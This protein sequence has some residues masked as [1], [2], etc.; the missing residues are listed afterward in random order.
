MLD[1]ERDVALG[2]SFFSEKYCTKPKEAYFSKAIPH[3]SPKNGVEEEKE[4]KTTKEIPKQ[5]VQNTA[6][7]VKVK[8]RKELEKEVRTKEVEKNICYVQSLRKEEKR[9]TSRLR[10]L[11]RLK[12]EGK[13]ECN[14]GR[15]TQVTVPQIKRRLV[16]VRQQRLDLQQQMDY[17]QNST[18]SIVGRKKK[19]MMEKPSAEKREQET[20]SA[21]KNVTLKSDTDYGASNLADGWNQEVTP[22]GQTYYY[23]LDTQESRWDAPLA[24]SQEEPLPDGWSIATAPN[25]KRYYFN[26]FQNISCWTRPTIEKKKEKKKPGNGDRKGISST[27]PGESSLEEKGGREALSTT[28]QNKVAYS[29]FKTMHNSRELLSALIQERVPVMTSMEWMHVRV[30]VLKMQE[31]LQKLEDLEEKLCLLHKSTRNIQKELDKVNSEQ[32]NSRL[33]EIQKRIEFRNIGKKEKSEKREKSKEPLAMVERDD[34][35]KVAGQHKKDLSPENYNY[36]DAYQ[37]CQSTARGT[38]TTDEF[39]GFLKKEGIKFKGDVHSLILAVNTEGTGQLEYIEFC[40]VLREILLEMQKSRQRIFMSSS[41]E[42]VVI[43]G[44]D[45]VAEYRRRVYENDY[46]FQEYHTLVSQIK[47]ID[48][49]KILSNY[50]MIDL[51]SDA[52][53]S[54]LSIH[55]EVD[56]VDPETGLDENLYG[57]GKLLKEKR[58]KKSI[59]TASIDEQ[60]EEEDELQQKLLGEI[61]KEADLVYRLTHR[62]ELVKAGPP[63][64][65]G[66]ETFVPDEKEL[67]V[68]AK[69][70]YS[71]IFG[72]PSEKG[73][74]KENSNKATL[75]RAADMFDTTGMTTKEIIAEFRRRKKEA[76]F[77]NIHLFF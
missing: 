10:K 9:L 65:A 34:E 20:S 61:R 52:D 53:T 8:Q 64:L 17:F 35:E 38:V 48:K 43:G 62:S 50:D 32:T 25:G 57:F 26:S 70:N 72:V 19:Y 13:K 7:K 16:E 31:K 66:V 24:S 45:K 4:K 30:L 23:N 12:A 76:D 54:A 29:K 51:S 40:A 21:E 56:S 33:E 47:D 42:Q 67:E 28:S 58:E 11:M 71:S 41:G 60:L 74:K 15:R 5:S 63:G 68:L 59:E 77:K 73:N 37:R 1:S 44:L 3:A 36:F 6:E 2:A 14:Y 18:R 39:I 75:Q 55:N 22:D 69:G 49:G 27:S 46:S